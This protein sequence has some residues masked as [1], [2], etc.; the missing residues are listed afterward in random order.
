MDKRKREILALVL[1]V[2]LGISVASAM[3]W[4]ILVGHN[5]NKAA[6]HIDDLVGSMDGYTVIVYEGVVPR[7]KQKES[8]TSGL[9]SLQQ[10]AFG[11]TA[12]EDT[13][14]PKKSKH[15]IKVSLS[16]VVASY[17]EKGASVVTLHLNDLGRYEDPFVVSKGGKRIGISVALG[18]YR[19]A[20][21]RSKVRA[22]EKAKADSIIMIADDSGFRKGKLR[23]ID[24]V[25]LARNARIEPEGRY[26][27]STF[28]V[29]S[30]YVGDV[31]AVIISP[32]G[33]IIS[34]S[35]TST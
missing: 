24:I 15:A 30:P 32:S 22:L 14:K 20:T 25:V 21:V 35:I 33:T 3:A 31:Q 11:K 29:D 8:D 28:F 6:S 2:L 1:L 7:P 18:K 34:K 27:S 23:D 9:A 10:V 5:W 19:Y 17:Q 16:K 13:A 26:Y 12:L 4:Y